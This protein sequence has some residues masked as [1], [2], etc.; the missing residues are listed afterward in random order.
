MHGECLVDPIR[1]V[2]FSKRYLVFACTY[3]ITLFVLD[4][5]VETGICDFSYLQ[6]Y[7][8]V[9]LIH[10]TQFLTDDPVHGIVV[11]FDKVGSILSPR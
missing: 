1:R 4:I 8:L 11:R 5:L 2:A 6:H 9:F 10:F 3:A 7:M